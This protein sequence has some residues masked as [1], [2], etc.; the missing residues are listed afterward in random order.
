MLTDSVARSATK[1]RLCGQ[2]RY[3]GPLSGEIGYGSVGGIW[4]QIHYGKTGGM[5]VFFVGLVALLEETVTVRK[6]R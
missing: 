5:L 2:T 4:G 3:E 6:T 1:D